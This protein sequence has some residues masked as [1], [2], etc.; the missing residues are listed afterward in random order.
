MQNILFPELDLD[1]GAAGY[2]I[3]NPPM[4]LMVPLIA[5]LQVISLSTVLL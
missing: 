4:M 5:F 3:S 2:R 1:T